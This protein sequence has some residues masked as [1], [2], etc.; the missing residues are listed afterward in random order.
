MVKRWKS[1]HHFLFIV[2]GSSFADKYDDAIR[3]EMDY[4]R[5]LG[6]SVAFYDG[7]SDR[8]AR[9]KDGRNGITHSYIQTHTHFL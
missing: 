6:A 3:D 4:G 8:R 7:V 1:L 5:V 9:S 2:L